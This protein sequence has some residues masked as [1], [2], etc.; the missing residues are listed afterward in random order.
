MVEPRIYNVAPAVII[1]RGIGGRA[2]VSTIGEFKSLFLVNKSRWLEI[3]CENVIGLDSFN[4]L[5]L[6]REKRKEATHF[7]KVLES[8]ISEKLLIEFIYAIEA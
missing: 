2:C 8:S 7:E 5:I 6:C 4:F 3:C 1:G